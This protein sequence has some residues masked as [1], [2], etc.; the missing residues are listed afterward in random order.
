MTVKSGGEL[1]LTGENNLS[2]VQLINNG[3]VNVTG[4]QHAS[5]ATV[6]NTGTAI[7]IDITGDTCSRPTI[8]NTHA[9][10]GAR[11]R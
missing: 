11:A 1:D 9:H 10:S 4:T 6:F 8:P 7:A 3:Q 2:G 5:A